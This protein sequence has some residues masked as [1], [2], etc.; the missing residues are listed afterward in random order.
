[1]SLLKSS[2]LAEGS[3]AWKQVCKKSAWAKNRVKQGAVKALQGFT[4]DSINLHTDVGLEATPS[5]D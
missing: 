4:S 5:L 1:M 2:R 3:V